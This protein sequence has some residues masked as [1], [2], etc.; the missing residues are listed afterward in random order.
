MLNIKKYEKELR[1]TGLYFALTKEGRLVDCE[2]TYCTNCTFNIGC[3][4]K[5]MN[6][7][8]Q[9]YK[10]PILNAKEKKYLGMLIKPF[11][12]RVMTIKK[13]RP[14]DHE[15]FVMI[16]VRRVTDNLHPETIV[17]PSFDARS[18]MYDGMIGNK[19]YTLEELGL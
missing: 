10:E 8:L 3:A 12:D 1:K 15:A 2:D 14:Y 5:R 4:I 9:E 13:S 16:E 17:L 7:L 11:R 6:W 19:K 18:G